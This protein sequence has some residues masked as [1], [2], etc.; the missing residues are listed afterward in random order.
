[1]RERVL[2]K[3]QDL[4]FSTV[5]RVEL[6]KLK[7]DKP[8]MFSKNITYEPELDVEFDEGGID[9]F[10]ADQGETSVDPEPKFEEIL[11]EKLRI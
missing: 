11:G 4:D 7:S 1:M 3:D 9:P 5:K 2:N 6:M 10:E 8:K